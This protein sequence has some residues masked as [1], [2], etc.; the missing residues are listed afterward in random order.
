MTILFLLLLIY[1]TVFQVK[2]DKADSEV[3]QKLKTNLEEQLQHK[4][5]Q[6]TGLEEEL[7]S[8]NSTRLKKYKDVHVR[9]AQVN[10]YIEMF[11]EVVSN[12]RGNLNDKEKQLVV[13]LDH[14]LETTANDSIE[15]IDDLQSKIMPENVTEE[16]KMLTSRI[17]R[18]RKKYYT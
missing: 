1:K 7:D 3:L 8:K 13:A 4:S 17:A 5:E 2:D 12:V 9:H 18:V 16:F 6:L 10:N 15:E 11:D 14:L